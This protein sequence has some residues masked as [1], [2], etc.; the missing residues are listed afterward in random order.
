VQLV[1]VGLN[2]KT[3]PVEVRDAMAIVPARLTQALEQAAGWPGLMEVVILSTCNRTEV[4]AVAEDERI[5][6]TSI[7][8]FLHDYHSI[9]VERIGPHLY[10]HVG[11]DAVRHIFRVIS[12]LDSMVLGEPQITG[13]VK[14]AFLAART[15]RTSG[16]LLDRLHQNALRTHKRVRTETRLGEGAVSIS[17]VAVELARKIFGDLSDRS[18]LVLGAGEMSELTLQCLESAG[19]KSILVSNR[20]HDKAVEL[21]RR[22]DWQVVPWEQFAETLRHADIVISSTAASHTVIRLPMVKDAMSRRRN[23]ALFLID[24]AAPRDIEP[25]VGELYNVFL[26]N[27]DDLNQI[28]EE[29][30]RQRKAEATAAETIVEAETEVFLRWQA[31]LDVKSIIVS[32]RNALD[33][34][35]RQELEWLRPKAGDISDREWENIVKFSKRLMNKFLHHPTST[36]REASPEDRLAGLAEAARRL[37]DLEEDSEGGGQ[38]E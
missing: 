19:A 2:H 33:E 3:A 31:S 7:L 5:G 15:A 36:L 6:G 29:N 24:I 4:W 30:R 14:D 12:G 1:I 32:L 10:R 25:E 13:Q 18:V 37:F 35:R 8:T 21:A 26:F 9:S 34:F 27:L 20:T 16:F 23:E 28:A 17:Y 22:H 11:E 38:Q